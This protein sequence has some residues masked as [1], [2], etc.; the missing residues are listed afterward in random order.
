[1]D[2]GDTALTGVAVDLAKQNRDFSAV[3]SNCGINGVNSSA[4]KNTR[5]LSRYVKLIDVFLYRTR[6]YCA[7]K[8]RETRRKIL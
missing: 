1:M 5:Y 6:E 8:S 3:L 4:Q 7:R 2:A